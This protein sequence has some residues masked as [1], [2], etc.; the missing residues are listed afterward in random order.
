MVHLSQPRAGVIEVDFSQEPAFDMGT[1][2]LDI[3]FGLSTRAIRS[4]SILVDDGGNPAT[5]LSYLVQAI[6]DAGFQA[7]MEPALEA[8]FRSMREEAQQIEQIRARKLTPIPFPRPA[9]IG[10][11]RHILPHQ[12]AAITGSLRTLNPANFSVPDRKSVV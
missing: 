2:G 5:V 3:T 11:T 9:S 6:A 12:Q 8:S 1:H 10:I 4:T 7:G